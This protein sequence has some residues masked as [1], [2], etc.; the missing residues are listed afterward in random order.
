MI[1]SDLAFC[2]NSECENK[3]IGGVSTSTS[4][5]ASVG[6]GYANVQAL[7]LGFGGNTFAFTKVNTSVYNRRN[8][9][10]SKVS[11]VAAA[12]A[13]DANGFSWSYLTLTSIA[14]TSKK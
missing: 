7:A 3:I 2:E 1:I 14:I 6:T 13:W 10:I 11:A 5:R 12:M 8:V 9:T 4:I